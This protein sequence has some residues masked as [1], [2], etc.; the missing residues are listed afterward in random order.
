M[1]P[2]KAPASIDNNVSLDGNFAKVIISS[3]VITLLLK[4][5]GHSTLSSYPVT[6]YIVPQTAHLNV[7][8]NV[9]SIGSSSSIN[10]VIVLPSL[11]YLANLLLP[12]LSILLNSSY[13]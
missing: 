3:A 5:K 1:F 7:K 4:H 8:Y 9:V 10:I 11:I 2:S 6:L 13:Y 12:L